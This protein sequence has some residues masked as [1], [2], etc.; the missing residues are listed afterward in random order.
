M[1]AT[2]PRPGVDI[3]TA[4]RLQGNARLTALAGVTLVG[5][6]AAQVVTV[7]LGVRNV[8]TAHVVIGLLLTPV[9]GVK[10]AS[11]CWRMVRYYLGDRRYTA[12]GAPPMYLRV[13]GPV[14]ILLTVTLLGSGLLLY[15][16]PHSLYAVTLRTHKVIFYPWL[17]ALLAHLVPH[18][19]NAVRLAAADLFA[20][21]R[22]R[23][24]VIGVGGSRAR[25]AAL[26]AAL[27]AGVAL[28]FVL[29]R[30]VPG[31]QQ[32]HPHH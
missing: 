21:T 32:A 24:D 29:Y 3:N 26:I 15:I 9:V 22:A 1:T 20:R 4:N 16:G 10:L 6:F 12:R 19:L 7:I 25:R 11:V 17:L 5:L 18:Y 27:A 23:I 8:L 2:T 14:L 28:A 31:Y 30:Y 13:L